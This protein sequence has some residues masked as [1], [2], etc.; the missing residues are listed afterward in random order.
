MTLTHPMARSHQS[1]RDFC[2]CETTRLHVSQ[3]K[4][5][6]AKLVKNN[7]Q[8]TVVDCYH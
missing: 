1:I 4:C 6:G 3:Q 8:I 7:E 5:Q 2:Q